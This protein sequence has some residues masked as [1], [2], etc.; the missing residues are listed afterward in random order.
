M[1]SAPSCWPPARCPSFPRPVVTTPNARQI[2]STHDGRTPQ[3]A[4]EYFERLT[5]HFDH[6]HVT[7]VR[8]LD[9]RDIVAG[10]RSRLCIAPRN[11]DGNVFIGCAVYDQLRDAERHH[12]LRR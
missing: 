12:F 3:P 6:V 8:Q 2:T 10:G 5:L 9:Q 7:S 4:T 11:F 1:A